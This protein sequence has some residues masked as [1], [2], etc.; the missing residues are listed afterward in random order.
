MGRPPGSKN[1]PRDAPQPPR[2]PP[3]RPSG[4]PPGRPAGRP[5]RDS[6]ST[7]ASID[8]SEIQYLDET[9]VLKPLQSDDL[10]DSNWPIFVLTDAVVYRRTPDGKPGDI[11]N[12]CN[13]D[14]EGPFIIQGKLDVDL[15]HSDQ[16]QACTFSLWQTT[17]SKCCLFFC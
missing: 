1:R 11:A 7:V 10:D 2:R 9:A 14:L 6:N 8:S 12:A 13:V 17:P 15:S 5:R 3:G 16:A 4:R